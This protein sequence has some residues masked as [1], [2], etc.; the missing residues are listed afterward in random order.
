M[1]ADIMKKAMGNSKKSLLLWESWPNC[2][3]RSPE[4]KNPGHR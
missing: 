2:G 3:Q 1:G 4:I